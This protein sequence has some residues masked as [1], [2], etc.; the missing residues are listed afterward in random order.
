M[1]NLIQDFKKKNLILIRK[2]HYKYIEG[3]SC[4]C[5]DGE[6]FLRGSCVYILYIH[7]GYQEW[8]RNQSSNC[9]GHPKVLWQ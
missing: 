2:P 9:N 8:E 4:N 3:F 1:Q 7:K 5:I 6:V